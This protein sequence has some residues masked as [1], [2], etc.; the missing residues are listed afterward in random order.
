MLAIEV[1]PLRP[2]LVLA[3]PDAADAQSLCARV[4]ANGG[5][6]AACVAIAARDDALALATMQHAVRLLI[7][8]Q[9][10]SAASACSQSRRACL[11]RCPAIPEPPLSGGRSPPPKNP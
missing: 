1:L 4:L 5:E 9:F 11:A 10:P 7:E 8:S 2:R 3:E 6:L